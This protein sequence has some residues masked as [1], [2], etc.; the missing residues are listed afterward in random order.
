MNYF[1][2]IL[3]T[4]ISLS[5]FKISAQAENKDVQINTFIYPPYFYKLKNGSWGGAS[6]D[7]LKAAFIGA[8]YNP[9][10]KI[11]PY[12]RSV[13][14]FLQS[15]NAIF[16]GV[17]DAIPGHEKF[18]MGQISYTVFPSS[19]FYNSKLHPELKK[20]ETIKET[21]GMTVSILSGT[22]F[23]KDIITENG[24]NPYEVINE[25]QVLKM[26]AKGRV[27]FGH[28]GNLTGIANIKNI[29]ELKDLRPMKNHASVIVGGVVF[30]S[31]AFKV[32]KRVLKQM[33]KMRDS[34]ELLKIYANALKHLPMANPESLVPKIISER[35]VKA[36]K[37][38]LKDS[39]LHQVSN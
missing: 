10:F 22:S 32:K 27:H 29:P 17:I 3:F 11:F 38:N 5:S 31:G 16:M 39:T 14:Q 15:E 9:V 20:I 35:K 7:A 28:S 33:R 36:K 2:V 12:K 21:K 23:Y 13:A 30:R 25:L 4:F 34:G 1:T 8:G 37:D 26:V 24:G 18:D 6:H 19:Y